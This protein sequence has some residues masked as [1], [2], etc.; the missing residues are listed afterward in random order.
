MTTRYELSRKELAELLDGEPK[1]RVDQVWDGLY[2]QCKEPHEIT[3]VPKQ[4]RTAFSELL[5]AALT[6]VRETEADNGTTVKQLWSV[7]SAPL[8]KLALTET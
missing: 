1:Y 7:A 2:S 6:L 3:N 4:L 5:P 8:A